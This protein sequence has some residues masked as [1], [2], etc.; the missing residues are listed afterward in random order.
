MKI[1]GFFFFS[2]VYFFIPQQLIAQVENKNIDFVYVDHIRSVAF[3]PNGLVTSMP[4][5]NLGA[6]AQLLLSFDDLDADDKEYIYKI[7]HC[8]YDWT[9]SEMQE[10]DFLRGFNGEEI[11]TYDYSS[12]TLREYTHYE[13]ALPNEDINWLLSGNYLVHVYDNEDEEKIV[14]TRRFMIVDTKMSIEH[15]FQTP[16]ISNKYNTHQ[17]I[18]FSI[19]HEGIKIKNPRSDIKVYVMQNGRWDGALKDLKPFFVKNEV[20]SYDYQDEIIFPAGKEFRFFDLRTL[21]YRGSFVKELTTDSDGYNALLYPDESRTFKNY[22]SFN[23]INGKFVIQNIDGLSSN[24]NANDLANKIGTNQGQTGDLQ[25]AIANNNQI[26]QDLMS[27]NLSLDDRN[28]TLEGDYVDVYFVLEKPL[29]LENASVYV[30]GG[31]TDWQAKAAYKLE[32]NAERNAY[33]TH[34]LLKQGFYNYVYGVLPDGGKQLDI[35]QLE[36]NWYE[37]EN[38]YTI[39]V[40]YRPF[41]SRYDQL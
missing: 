8:N 34:A 22:S 11:E 15:N 39:L 19:R 9:P 26:L 30:I 16:A 20:L 3:H 38:E 18:D 23:D 17:E 36:G 40:Y 31:F 1:Y 12:N 25:Q 2:W 32:Y 28:H 21:R 35:E 27:S 13:L 7:V 37:T 24:F 5:M 41:G 6:Q 10:M 14:L 33:Y 4:V 29:P